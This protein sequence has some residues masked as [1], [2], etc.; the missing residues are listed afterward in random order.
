[1]A[2]VAKVPDENR[3][4]F[5]DN[6]KGWL[7]PQEVAEIFGISVLT[8]YSWKCKA[9][10]RKIPEDLFIK[11]NRQLYVRTDVLQRWISSQNGSQ[12]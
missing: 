2:E 7:R 3:D 9:K 11:F 6:L 5:F 8:I 12:N 4:K 10:T 1:M